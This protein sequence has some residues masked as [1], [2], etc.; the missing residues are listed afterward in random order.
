[1]LALLMNLTRTLSEST[2]GQVTD[3]DTAGGSPEVCSTDG[4]L[5]RP[6]SPCGHLCFSRRDPTECSCRPAGNMHMKA[7]PGPVPICGSLRKDRVIT[8]V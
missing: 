3:Q 1:M 4:L 2:P 7:V 6:L 5:E 8:R